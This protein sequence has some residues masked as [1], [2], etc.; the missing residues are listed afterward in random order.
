M[1]ATRRLP[2]PITVLRNSIKANWFPRRAP[3]S[4]R[5]MCL[6]VTYRCNMRCRMCGIWKQNGSHERP[7]LSLEEFDRILSDPFFSGL[8]FI[9]IN[10]GEPNLRTD[11][12]ALVQM[13]TK[14]FPRLQ[15][16]SMNSNGLP[17]AVLERNAI[18]ISRLCRNRNINFSISLS[19]HEIGSGLDDIAGIRNAYPQVKD[20]FDRLKRIRSE[21]GFYLSANCVITNLNLDSLDGLRRWSREQDIPVNFTLGEIRD[22]FHNQD[23]KDDVLIDPAH[24][25]LLISFFKSLSKSKRTYLQHALRYAELADM[26]GSGRKRGLS[27]H[28]ALAGVILGSDGSLYYCKNSRPLGNCLERTASDCFYDDDNQAYRNDVL[29]RSK[30]PQCPPNTFNKI[31]VEKDL[32]KILKHFIF[33]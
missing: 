4:L 22:R 5:A 19:L 33:T 27:C 15:T 23:M 14:K 20:A 11:L 8:E 6:Y 31:E 18:E 30:C 7:E 3:F 21:C 16:V 13:L 1:R 12:V 25:E 17:P 24:Q 2:S 28:Y 32:L 26:L 9:N 10:G 29:L